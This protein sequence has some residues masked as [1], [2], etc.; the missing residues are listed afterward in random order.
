VSIVRTPN[1]NAPGGVFRVINAGENSPVTAGYQ[2]KFGVY[3]D[4]TPV[5]T[6]G[7]GGFGGGGGQS[8]DGGSR[9]GGPGERDIVQGRPPYEPKRVESD[10]E[11]QGFGGGSGQ[12]PPKVLL[13]FA[14]ENE[15]LISG[16]FDGG[17][18]LAGRAALVQ[19]K[20]G[21]GNILLFGI[22][23]MWRMQTQGSWQLIFNA[24]MTWNDMD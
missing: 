24:A 7:F 13:R 10:D 18:E 20:L 3:F 8:D 16:M 12:T 17:E 21:K 2:G 15:L 11:Q 19:C 9:R 6:T 5:L 22:N 14:A 1:L 4:Q 23:P